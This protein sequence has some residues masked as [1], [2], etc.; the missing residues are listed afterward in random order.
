VLC[1]RTC[2]S[3]F[4]NT[5]RYQQE[6]QRCFLSCLLE[7]LRCLCTHIVLAGMTHVRGATGAKAATGGAVQC[8]AN[9][10]PDRSHPPLAVYGGLSF[11]AVLVYMLL[12]TAL[13]ISPANNRSTPQPVS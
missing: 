9:T 1:R 8:N 12:P 2:Q 4:K 6:G 7:K 13:M 3:I 10:N 11:M 5:K